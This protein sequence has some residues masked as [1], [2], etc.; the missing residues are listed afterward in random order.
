MPCPPAAQTDPTRPNSNR[1]DPTKAAV[2]ARESVQAPEVSGLTDV[3]DSRR[4]H[5]FSLTISTTRAADRCRC[6][7]VG[8]T[9][10]RRRPI[11]CWQIEH[12]HRVPARVRAEVG[13]AHRHLDRGVTKQLSAAINPSAEQIQTFSAP[14]PYSTWRVVS[15][16]LP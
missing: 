5:P 15:P 3:F 4:L 1:P 8:R 11:R 6:Q 10:G 16:E 9:I 13:V 12:A 7:P 2:S 14:A